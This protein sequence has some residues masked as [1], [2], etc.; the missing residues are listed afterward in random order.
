MEAVGSPEE[1]QSAFARLR[2]LGVEVVVRD[3]DQAFQAPLEELGLRAQTCLFHAH[4]ALGRALRKLG[5][6]ERGEWRELIGLIKDA[7]G[8]LPAHPPEALFVAHRLS[9]PPPVQGLV[10]YL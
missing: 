4:R 7:L 9:L 8:S 5:P 3:G 2:A 6:E 1:Y 10:V